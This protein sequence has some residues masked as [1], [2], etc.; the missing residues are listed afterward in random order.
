MSP[1]INNIVIRR[2]SLLSEPQHTGVLPRLVT[3]KY[4]MMEFVKHPLI[5]NGPGDPIIEEG[6]EVYDNAVYTE[7][8]A[9]IEPEFIF[10]IL[11]SVLHDSGIIG[12]FLFFLMLVQY[13][14]F[15]FK[16]IPRFE[17]KFQ[18]INL[19][20]LGGVFS[21]FASY[22]LTNGL[23]I[24]FTWVLLALNIVGV[25]YADSALLQYNNGDM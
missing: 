10:S 6:T 18:I 4:A 14:K 15:N 13:L 17:P 25:Q 2:I 24:P 11:V 22:I 12:F 3:A 5:G 7:D 16:K 21:L 19:A 1:T 9:L 8:I 23:W 20:L